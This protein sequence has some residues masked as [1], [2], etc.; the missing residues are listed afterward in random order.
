[1]PPSL[2]T[3]LHVIRN[4]REIPHWTDHGRIAGFFHETMRPWNDALPDVS[5]GLDHALSTTDDRSGFVLLAAHAE[6]LSGGLA[7]LDTGLGGFVPKY[8]LLFVAVRPDLRGQGIGKT[9]VQQALSMCD[10]A[11]KLHVEY[12]NPAKH[13]YERLGFSTKYAEMRYLP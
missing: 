1:M 3:C 12:D 8:L 9:L 2:E 10:G 11:V 5:K 13:L 4:P 7:M 6:E